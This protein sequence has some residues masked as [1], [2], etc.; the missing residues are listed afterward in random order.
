MND[1]LITRLLLL[2]MLL[3]GLQLMLLVR[4]VLH[5]S[6]DISINARIVV[7]H[8]SFYHEINVVFQ[9]KNLSLFTFYSDE[10]FLVR[11]L[12]V[13]VSISTESKNKTKTC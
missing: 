3:N 8:F 4:M 5:L 1:H 11:M 2:L 9:K 7:I 12:S 10:S 13:V 6:T